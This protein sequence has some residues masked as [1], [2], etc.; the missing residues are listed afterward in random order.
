MP[1]SNED[2]H[3]P[4][5]R[6]ILFNTMIN[7]S[8]IAERSDVALK[9]FKFKV[10][11]ASSKVPLRSHLDIVHLHPIINVPTKYQHPTPYCL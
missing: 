10:T 7:R 6:E 4:Q 2:C 8:Y 11:T 9:S 1:K 3:T 5:L